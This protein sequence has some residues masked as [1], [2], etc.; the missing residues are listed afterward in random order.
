MALSSAVASLHHRLRSIRSAMTAAISPARVDRAAS[1]CG[2]SPRPQRFNNRYARPPLVALRRSRTRTRPRR[3]ER[4]SSFAAGRRTRGRRADTRG[5]SSPPAV[6]PTSQSA[7]CSQLPPIRK[8]PLRTQPRSPP[9]TGPISACF[10][11]CSTAL[12]DFERDAISGEFSFVSHYADAASARE[13]LIRAARLS[14]AAARSLRHSRTH[15]MIVY[16][17]AGYYAAS[18]TQD[19]L[20]SQLAP[21]LVA[22]L[23]PTATPIILA[24]RAQHRLGAVRKQRCSAAARSR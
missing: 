12:L 22:A 11:R 20:A 21:S 19:S 10:P 6:T 24:L 18:A 13:G 3:T 7:H 2:R 15:T 17:V 16:G 5:G 14:L 4:S 8:Q 23:G 1:G 9:R